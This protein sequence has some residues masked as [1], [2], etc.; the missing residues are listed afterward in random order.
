MEAGA[1]RDRLLT[2]RFSLRPCNNAERWRPNPTSSCWDV[3]G[4]N[5]KKAGTLAGFPCCLVGDTGIEPVTSTVGRW[6]S[7]AELIA[8][9]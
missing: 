9:F 8:L 4:T 7:T 6:H 2:V 3:A 1:H 5:N